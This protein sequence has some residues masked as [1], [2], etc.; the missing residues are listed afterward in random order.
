MERE[1]TYIADHDPTGTAVQMVKEICRDTGL[2]LEYV[3]SQFPDFI[4]KPVRERLA[5]KKITQDGFLHKCT[6]RKY[7]K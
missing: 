2:N 6:V 4:S 5:S 3:L 7:S 1:N